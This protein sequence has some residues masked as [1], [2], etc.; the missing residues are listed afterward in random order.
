MCYNEATK[1]VKEYLTAERAKT[2]LN[3]WMPK[4]KAGAQQEKRG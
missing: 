1:S 3:Y 4:R 2:K